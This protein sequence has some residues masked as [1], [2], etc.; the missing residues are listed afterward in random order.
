VS[1]IDSVIFNKVLGVFRSGVRKLGIQNRSGFFLDTVV[2]EITP[3]GGGQPYR[4]DFFNI[5]AGAFT[6]VIDKVSKKESLQAKV[7]SVIF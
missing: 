5:K 3:G 7:Q 1:V 2:V 6:V 4:K